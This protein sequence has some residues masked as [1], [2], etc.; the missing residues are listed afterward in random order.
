MAVYY[1]EVW[2]EQFGDNSVTRV[3]AII[4]MVDEIFAEQSFQTEI[5]VELVAAELAEGENWAKYPWY[6]D[7]MCRYGPQ[8][9]QFFNQY[10]VCFCGSQCLSLN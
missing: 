9:K 6:P 3:D 4:A 1:D 2:H 8:L 5:D 10:F 7:T